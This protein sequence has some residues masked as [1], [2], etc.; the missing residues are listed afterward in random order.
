MCKLWVLSEHSVQTGFLSASLLAQL[1]YP[2]RGGVCRLHHLSTCQ[3]RPQNAICQFLV[4]E[5]LP[6]PP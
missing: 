4:R 3:S 6:S 2:G 5:L 1:G